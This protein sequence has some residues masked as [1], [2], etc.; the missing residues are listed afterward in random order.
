MATFDDI[1]FEVFTTAILPCLSAVDVGRLAQA[2][3]MWRDFTDESI[4]WKSLYL[5]LTPAKILN[6]SIHIGPRSMRTRDRHREYII[7]RNTGVTTTATTLADP[8]VV[9]SLVNN[10]K[11]I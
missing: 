10:R 5:H 1:P 2:N 9:E 11:N 7:L 8:S 6:T 3:T 4:V